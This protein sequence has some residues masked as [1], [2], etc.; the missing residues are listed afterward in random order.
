MSRIAALCIPRH[1]CFADKAEDLCTCRLSTSGNEKP[2]GQVEIGRS[3]NF[4]RK[5]TLFSIHNMRQK[6]R[7]TL[8]P[9]PLL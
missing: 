1:V 2:T 3:L 7:S 4:S 5:P 6:A 9:N 8:Y